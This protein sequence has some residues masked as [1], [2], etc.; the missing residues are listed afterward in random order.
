M[1]LGMTVSR[2]FEQPGTYDY[3]CAIH[4]ASMKG[5]ITVE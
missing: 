1:G 5:Q 4:P 3:V 2:T